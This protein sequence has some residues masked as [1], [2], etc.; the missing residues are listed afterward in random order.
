MSCLTC[1]PLPTMSAGAA[2]LESSARPVAGS[3]PATEVVEMEEATPVIRKVSMKDFL[4]SALG[5]EQKSADV[6]S[7]ARRQQLAQQ[8][9]QQAK[10]QQQQQPPQ[11]QRVLSP[12]GQRGSQIESKYN[13]SRSVHN[14]TATP[15]K[16]CNELTFV[17][18]AF[19]IGS[20]TWHKRCARCNHCR[21]YYTRPCALL[22][23][24]CSLLI[25]NGC[26]V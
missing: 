22:I 14:S 17:K 4:T 23:S 12:R 26:V 5:K 24:D 10:L 8:Q 15:C 7:Q 20:F 19:V 21:Y 1:V 16:A 6:I 25:V 2:P 3:R 9:Q 11:Q 18:E 13:M